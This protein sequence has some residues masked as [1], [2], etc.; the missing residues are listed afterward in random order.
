ML[1]V[2]ASEP[3]IF[4]S[5]LVDKINGMESANV[6]MYRQ[7][8][9]ET[10]D[11]QTVV[12]DE[13]GRTRT[14]SQDTAAAVL[15]GAFLPA[16]LLPEGSTSAKASAK[17]SN[18]LYDEHGR[19]TA[20]G[21][22][23]VADV[24]DEGIMRRWIGSL[25]K[26][27]LKGFDQELRI[28][29]SKLWTEYSKLQAEHE[30]HLENADYIFFGLDKDATLEDLQKAFRRLARL[31]HPD[32]NGGSD[33]AKARFQDLKERYE[34]LKKKILGEGADDEDQKELLDEGQD[35]DE[36]R[37]K[38]GC[39][40]DDLDRDQREKKIWELYYAAQA[41]QKQIRS[42]KAKLDSEGTPRS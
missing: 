10:G 31:M 23:S 16:R 30:D 1:S 42:I 27:H 13:Q 22:E 2:T 12:T 41:M 17:Q 6:Q 15:S 14:F 35:L 39:D 32:K 8:N 24:F 11:A 3:A 19:M 40:E 4:V 20:P 37:D 25:S 18:F 28:R 26:C 7:V 36:N 34:A 29:L 21:D 9:S 5:C 33:E 38:N